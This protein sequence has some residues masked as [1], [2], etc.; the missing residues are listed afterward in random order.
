MPASRSGKRKPKTVV[1]SSPKVNTA[2]LLNQAKAEYPHGVEL[3]YWRR[4]SAPT[5]KERDFWNIVIR[6]F[7][8]NFLRRN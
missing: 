2:K 7:E 3:W 4:I 1:P 5:K 8:N 6:N